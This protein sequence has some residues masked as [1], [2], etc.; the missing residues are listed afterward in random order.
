RYQVMV[1]AAAEWI[2]DVPRRAA[3]AWVGYVK[4]GR[5]AAEGESA[6]EFRLRPDRTQGQ[7][8]PTAATD[9]RPAVTKPRPGPGDRAHRAVRVSHDGFAEGD[10]RTSYMG[11]ARATRQVTYRAMLSASGVVLA[12]VF[13]DGDWARVA[14]SVKLQVGDGGVV[15]FQNQRLDVGADR[16]RED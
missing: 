13:I 7:T 12:S 14:G 8:G 4:A 3:T 1:V 11:L 5:P 15:E 2:G 6:V 16:A 10:Q 9:V